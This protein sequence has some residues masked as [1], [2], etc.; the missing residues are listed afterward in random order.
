MYCQASRTNPLPKITWQHQTGLCLNI[1]P[2]CKSDNTKWRDITSSASFVISPGDDV[3]T[4]KS[5]L[6]IPRDAPSAFFRCIARNVRGTRVGS[7]MSF[8][9]SGE[10]C[11]PVSAVVQCCW[12]C[13]ILLGVHW[14]PNF[15]KSV[16]KGALSQ[17]LTNF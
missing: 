17:I 13:G 1:N 9:A 6:T 11:E 3:A 5:T 14:K 2:E 15:E 16:F 12:R 7:T 10:L 8:F 4:T